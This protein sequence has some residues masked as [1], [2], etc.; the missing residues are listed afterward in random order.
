MVMKSGLAYA[1][2]KLFHLSILWRASVSNLEEF[3]AVALGPHEERLRMMIL[4]GTP[5]TPDEYRLSASILLRP[6]SRRVHSGVI[7]V[8]AATRHDGGWMYTSVYGGCIWHWFVSRDVSV[9]VPVLQADGTLRMV[10]IGVDDVPA[11]SQG[12]ARAADARR[13]SSRK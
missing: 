1:P 13:K 7:G 5:G 8:P 10:V 3:Q 9:D 6:A 4:T 12:L 2:F 11:V